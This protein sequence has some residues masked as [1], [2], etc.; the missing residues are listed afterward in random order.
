MLEPYQAYATQD[1]PPGWFAWHF[2]DYPLLLWVHTGTMTV[3]TDDAEHRI[4]A[5]EGVWFP[6]GVHHAMR[7]ERGTVAIWAG[8]GQEPAPSQVRVVPVPA[9]WRDWL[10]H[11]HN[12][13]P[14]T[15]DGPLLELATRPSHRV[16]PD[17]PSIRLP[18]PHS[19][20]ARTVAQLLLRNPGSPLQ[21]KDH[22]AREHVS[23]KTLQ[24]QFAGETGIRFAEWRTRARVRA[25][26]A[27]LATGQGVAAAQRHV[28]YLTAAG[29]TRAFERHLGVTPSAYANLTRSRPAPPNA[30]SE[31]EMSAH[32]AAM[33]ADRR[34]APPPIPPYRD[35]MRVND[36]HVLLWVFRGEGDL[37]IGTRDYQLRRGQAIWVPAGVPHRVELAA[38]SILLLLGSRYGRVRTGVDEL[39]IFSF[40]PQA[41]DFLL[42]TYLAEYSSL[43]HPESPPTLADELFD[44][45]FVRGLPD[46]DRLTG[47]V[48]I[49]ATALR[50]NPAD[51]RSLAGWA[52][53]LGTEPSTLG[54]EFT[55]QTGATFPH[56]R[57]Q[58]RMNLARELLHSGERPGAIATKLGYARPS[59]FTKVFTA[60]H[61][62]PPRE[63]QRQVT[64]S[65]GSNQAATEP[66][67]EN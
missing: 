35:S 7:L 25:A 19:R 41:E 44:E 65:P 56:W 6:A 26:A 13:G 61:G 16:P 67:P 46:Q 8:A 66:E 39:R 54:Q 53:T 22:A 18:M 59:A 4:S 48:G 20:E 45:Q 47:A 36:C 64:G 23:A 55:S 60:T 24:R 10:I 1:I 42:H 17:I 28:G 15:A 31:A 57:A 52:Q 14:T 29:F 3:L 38:E 58:L 43:L 62:I 12:L 9:A 33:V 11:K 27:Q 21:A 50:R 34:A 63:Y 5:G 49:V 30:A 51:P 32:L 2:N 37:Q 40:P